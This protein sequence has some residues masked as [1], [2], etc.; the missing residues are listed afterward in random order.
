MAWTAPI[1]HAAGD[2]LPAS[3]WNTYVA[4]NEIAL[5]NSLQLFA[6]AGNLVG[7][8]PAL[9]SPAYKIQGGTT[10]A[11]TST[12]GGLSIAWGTSFPVGVVT[13]LA[14]AGDD[15]VAGLIINIV[16]A[17]VTLAS[18]GIVAYTGVTALASTSI[19][20]NWIAIGF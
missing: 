6:I 20:V 5:E 3:D 8:P 7:A 4:N 16:A 18:F 12:G 13:V 19:R 15:T 10:V 9:G 2:V 14:M 1:Q 11:T 17:Q